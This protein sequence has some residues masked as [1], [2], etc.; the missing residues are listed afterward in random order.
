[1][2]RRKLISLIGGLAIA[3][4]LASY[5]Q[6]PIPAPPKHVGV[7]SLRPECPTP[8]DSPMLRRLGE[9]GWIEGRNIVF[10]CVSTFGRLD[11]LPAL[12]RELISLHPDVL[13]AVPSNFV[14]A[15]KLKT[16]AIPIVMV[17]TTDPLRGDLVTNLARPEGNVTGVAFFGADVTSKRLELLSEIFPH[18]RRLALV[19]S[20]YQDSRTAQN[21]EES[22]TI[23]ANRLGF[24][25]QRFRPVVANDYDEVFARIATERF[26]AAL[27]SPDPLNHQNAAR[28]TE[29]ALRHRIPT[30]GASVSWAK[31]GLLL[32]YGQDARWGFVRVAE[33]SGSMAK[34]MMRVTNTV[35]ILMAMSI[36]PVAQG[37][38]TNLARPGG[39]VTGFSVQAG[40]EIES[41]RMQLLKDTVPNMSRVAFLGL[42][43]DWEGTNGTALRSAAET[44]GLTLFFAEATR[45]DYSEAFALIAKE[46]PDAFIVAQN[47]AS[48]FHRHS[49]IAFALQHRV[50]AMFQSRELVDDGGLMS[51]SVDYPDNWRRVAGYIDRILKGEKPGELPIQQPTKF[52]LVINLKTAR[53]IGLEMPA[54]VLAQAD[55]VV[56]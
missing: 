47:P 22:A 21:L 24:T 53:A 34:E 39:N 33:Y 13:L 6:Q 40:P 48:W 42:E 29:L 46:R 19:A 1:M 3:W 38:V 35:P 7:L 37:I 20:E 50:P 9:L 16:T 55:E 26:D 28:I 51:Y 49:I 56:E 54:I 11:Q 45:S 36:D 23:A 25:W 43:I 31:G 17:A 30:V 5:A 18:L 52:E 32:S 14:R 41:K 44:Q 15:L 4:P 12:A 10:D 8:P 2:K 27:I